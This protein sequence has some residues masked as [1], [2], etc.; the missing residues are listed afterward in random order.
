MKNVIGINLF[1]G[2]LLTVAAV[3]D[4]GLADLQVKPGKDIECKAPKSPL[5]KAK[6]SNDAINMELLSAFEE[7]SK[8]SGQAQA[9]QN[10][11]GVLRYT[12]FKGK[13]VVM[14]VLPVLLSGRGNSRG[15]G[16]EFKPFR[17]SFTTKE[18]SEKIAQSLLQ[19]G[20]RPEDRDYL[21]QYYNE[22]KTIEYDVKTEGKPE[23]NSLFDGLGDD[24]KV[25]THCGKALMGGDWPGA[26]LEVD[27]DNRL[28]AEHYVYEVLNQTGLIVEKTRLAK[29]MYY[30]TQ[31][32]S[33]FKTAD[34][35]PKAKLAFFREPTTSAAKRC[36]LL[37]KPP[38]GDNQAQAAWEVDSESAFALYIINT[39]V[40]NSD[41]G[42]RGA[43][44]QGHNVNYFYDASG[45][46]YLGA[47]DF[48]QM[49][50]VE[51]IVKKRTVG[52]TWN[53]F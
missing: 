27:Q 53:W 20:V 40:G 22:F 49:E 36:G 15:G 1:I 50:V 25:V 13:V 38:S 19:K 32:E 48:G 51:A 10:I 12:E 47:Y 3:A 34:G 35:Q 28:L 24:V 17:L 6:D 21:T 29:F 44:K 30:N 31:G 52:F 41:Y 2:L 4:T 26:L 14:P 33:L 7:I 11:R 42:D 39:F 23:K 43:G 37:N 18:L 45:K 8:V 5:Y 46:R 16:C 9:N